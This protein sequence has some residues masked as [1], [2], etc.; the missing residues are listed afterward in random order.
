MKFS[1]LSFAEADSGLTYDPERAALIG[2]KLDYGVIVSDENDEYTVKVFAELP[3][4]HEKS[5]SE[6]INNLSKSLSKNTI[7]SQRCEYEFVEVRMNKYCLL[8]EKLEYLIDFLDKLTKLLSSLGIKGVELKLP[9]IVQAEKEKNTEKNV[10]KINLRFD[11][12]SIKG[13]FGA[14]IAGFASIWI[15]EMLVT[16]TPDSDIPTR[17]TINSYIIAVVTTAL[18]FFDYRFLA[19]KIDAFGVIVCPVIS[20]LTAVLSSVTVAA[21]VISGIAEIPFA[22]SFKIIGDLYNFNADAASFVEGYL[23]GGVL[24][25]IVSSVAVC[26]YYFNRYPDEMFSDEIIVKNK[27]ENHKK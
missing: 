18:I 17:G 6:G 13:L 7:N 12:N 23:V 27:P 26:V 20:V 15:A 24:L 2:K 19:K 22:E 9:E 11:L 16:V 14:L 5:I 8:Q 1:E 3:F 10:K 25:S 21:K 4:K